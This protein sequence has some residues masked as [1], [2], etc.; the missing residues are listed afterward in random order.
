M[1]IGNRLFAGSAVW[2]NLEDHQVDP[3]RP[4]DG[5][6]ELRIGRGTI[7]DSSSEAWIYAQSLQGRPKPWPP[8]RV[9]RATRC[10]LSGVGAPIMNGNGMGLGLRDGRVRETQADDALLISR[11][12][13]REMDAFK[14]LYRNYHPRLTRFL[15]KL[16]RRPELVEEV[17]N[18]TLMVVWERP[19]GFNGDS[20]L[21]TWIFA[22][23]YRK[24]MKS[25]RKQDDP[26]EDHRAHERISPEPSVEDNLGREGM[27]LLLRRAIRE[28]SPEHRAVVELTYFHELGYREI[29]QIMSCP[30]DTVKTRMFHARRHL[31]RRLAGEL[32]D[33]L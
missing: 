13:A 20:K 10:A 26:I 5:L 17:M 27:R 3:R 32:P 19:E 14:A 8:E 28:L 33:W 21:S 23:A 30:V 29:A 18:D 12:R 16:I 31:K 2:F 15:L 11:I 1:K 22:I 25:L 24:A 4:A 7:R 6:G 9:L